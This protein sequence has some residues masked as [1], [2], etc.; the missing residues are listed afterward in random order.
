MS[1]ARAL[2]VFKV[3]PR[4]RLLHCRRAAASPVILPGPAPS[5]DPL[6]PAWS[7]EALAKG[8]RACSPG[9]VCVCVKEN[10]SECLPHIHSSRDG[11]CTHMSPMWCAS[12]QVKCAS[13]CRSSVCAY[14]QA[15]A[16]V[17]AAQCPLP[18]RPPNPGTAPAATATPSRGPLQEA[19]LEFPC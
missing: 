8:P 12:S 14:R 3:H 6:C 4:Q 16:R 13:G 1:R 2:F 11:A 10:K 7:S 19:S 5:H 17:P 18:L 15:G 9:G